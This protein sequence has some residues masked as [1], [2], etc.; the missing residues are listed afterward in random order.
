ME[1]TVSNGLL[2]TVAVLVVAAILINSYAIVEI[3]NVNSI[4]QSKLA[5]DIAAKVQ[6]NVPEPVVSGTSNNSD[7]V[8]IAAIEAKLYESDN[9]ET[10]AEAIATGEWS[11][12]DYKDIYSAMVDLSLPIYEKSD[13]SSVVIEDDTTFSGMDAENKDGIVDQT[14]KVKYEDVNGN[15]A[16][17]YLT[18]E[19][20]IEDGDVTDQVIDLA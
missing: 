13:I 11:D 18:I 3:Q 17:V 15:H 10:S 20:D 6:I 9:W 12:K 1:K 8:K 4:D 16:K 5:S 19:T 7:S 2:W 14:V